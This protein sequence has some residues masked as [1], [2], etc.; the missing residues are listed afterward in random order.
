MINGEPKTGVQHARLFG[1]STMRTRTAYV[2]IAA[3]LL[4]GLL[5]GG[6]PLLRGFTIDGLRG[7]TGPTAAM[8]GSGSGSGSSMDVQAGGE[9]HIPSLLGRPAAVHRTR[10]ANAPR[11][12]FMTPVYT[13]DQL[14]A[15]QQT[16]DGL[17]D[18]CNGGWNVTVHVQTA[19]DLD[20][21]HPRYQEFQRR[22][23]CEDAGEH[24]PLLMEK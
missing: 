8:I 1:W 14:G 5:I 12:L 19:A 16:L 17:R 2:L 10:G 18:I 13:M 4:L 20:Y 3:A 6:S 9:R 21:E 23:W 15:F 24:V 11:L 22:L 7:G